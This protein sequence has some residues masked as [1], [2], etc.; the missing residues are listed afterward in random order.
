MDDLSMWVRATKRLAKQQ[1]I[2]WHPV[3]GELRFAG[4]FHSGVDAGNGLSDN[5]K[6]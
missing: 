5:L 1:A 4:D 2:R 3:G 6:G